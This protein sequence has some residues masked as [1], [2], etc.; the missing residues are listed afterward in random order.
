MNALRLLQAYGPAALITGASDGIG[1]AFA[2]ELAKA[3]FNLVI[4]ARRADRLE[5]LANALS[6]KHRV[7]VLP[8]PLDLTQAGAS[9]HLL[10]AAKRHDV[11]LFIACAGFGASGPL[12]AGDIEDELSMIDLNCRA[13][14]EQAHLIG[15]HLVARGGGGMILMGSLLGFQGVARAANYAATKAFVQVLAEGL[16]IELGADGVDVLA[17]A[18]GPVS[19]GFADRAN[20]QMGHAVPAR[21]VPRP[22]LRALGR[23]TTARPGLFTKLLSYSLAALPRGLRSRILTDAMNTMTRHQDEPV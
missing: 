21:R 18:P 7:T 13:V 3:G 20:M 2:H 1:E 8:V 22:T 17:C 15:R 4:S 10:E 16:R 6:A 5:S 14:A 11:G 19:S 12:L 9:Q 23:R